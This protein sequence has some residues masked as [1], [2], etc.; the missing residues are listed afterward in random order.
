M[1][2][3][4]VAITMRRVLNGVFYFFLQSEDGIRDIGVTGAQTCALPICLSLTNSGVAGRAIDSVGDV[5][6]WYY[7]S[8]F[9]QHG[10]I[11]VGGTATS[12]DYPNAVYTV[13]IGRAH[14]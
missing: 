10:F 2:H 3:A 11:I 7:D 1:T 12:I 4:R 8:S 14:V 9:L 5:G 13:E 6:G